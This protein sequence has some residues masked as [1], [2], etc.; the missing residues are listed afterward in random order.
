MNVSW[1]HGQTAA[2]LAIHEFLEARIDSRIAAGTAMAVHAGGVLLGAALYNNYFKAHGTIELQAAADSPRWLSRRTLR[3]LFSYPFQQLGCQAVVMRTDADNMRT[4]RVAW[5]YGFRRY[6]IPRL[7]G[8][9][10]S[11]IVLVLHD[12]EWAASK[13]NKERG[14]VQEGT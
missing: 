14:H 11:G 1:H 7:H 9:D 2:Y 12:D 6:E 10:K 4:Q 13:F 8:R 5:R 3:E